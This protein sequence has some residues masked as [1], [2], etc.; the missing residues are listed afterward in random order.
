MKVTFFKGLWAYQHIKRILDLDE[1]F[2]NNS[3]FVIFLLNNFGLFLN[4]D[5]FPPLSATPH[6]PGGIQN[7]HKDPLV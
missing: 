4:L 3:K 5:I 7:P 2:L 6:P 1:P